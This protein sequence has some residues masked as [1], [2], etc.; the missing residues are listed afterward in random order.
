MPVAIGFRA[1]S[2]WAAA[3]AVAAPAGSPTIVDR[4]RV[5]IA[6]LSRS[7]EVQPY[8][9]AAEMSLKHAK[10]FIAARVKRTR[11]LA[12]AAIRAVVRDTERQGHKIAGCGILLSSGRPTTSLEA[13]LASHPAIH[14]AEGH[15]FRNAIVHAAEQLGIPV[16]GVREREIAEVAANELGMAPGV[17]AK[18]VSELGRTLGPPWRQDEELATLAAWLALTAALR[19]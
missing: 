18:T 15:L 4:R 19:D 3:V 6:D 2:G 12:R 13:T 16:V 11:F 9:A 10:A 14:T 8:H 5:Q 1:H 17:I 7:E